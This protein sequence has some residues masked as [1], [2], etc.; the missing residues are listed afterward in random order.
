M[1]GDSLGISQC[2]WKRMMGLCWSSWRHTH[3]HT[4]T[5]T[6]AHTHTR[7]HTHTHTHTR[8][9]NTHRLVKWMYSTHFLVMN[10]LS[11]SVN[12][13][14]TS[15]TSRS[16]CSDW[17]SVSV[18]FLFLPE[19]VVRGEMGGGVLVLLPRRTLI[20]SRKP[21]VSRGA[22]RVFAVCVCVCVWRSLLITKVLVHVVKQRIRVETKCARS[23]FF[24]LIAAI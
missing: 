13:P 16:P 7:T 14:V 1:G 8:H 21:C 10:S 20:R 23:I 24:L 18:C 4:H 17:G 19:R 6:H 5:H 2:T 3:T 12:Q 11:A 9:S 22:V 15:P